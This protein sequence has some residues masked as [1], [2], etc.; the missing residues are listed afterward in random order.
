MS[1]GEILVI[2][3]VAVLVLG[4]EKLPDAAIQI[5]KFIKAAKK[6]I[7]DIKES[8]DK[9]V[10]INEMKEEAKK[11]KDE[12][13]QYNENIRKKLSFEEFDELKKDI[14][15][16]NTGPNPN[17]TTQDY[18]EIA[19]DDTAQKDADKNKEG[20]DVWRI[21]TSPCRA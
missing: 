13:S 12:F 16:N 15:T 9:E 19:A 17:P 8:L 4:P 10:R 21:K 6:H 5:A 7:D 11:Y 2:L 1:M 18:K 3:I 14:F 20:K